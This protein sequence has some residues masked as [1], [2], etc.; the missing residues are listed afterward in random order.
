MSR[1]RLKGRA[2][3]GYEAVARGEVAVDESVGS[4]VGE[5]GRD[6]RADGDEGRV[7]ETRRALHQLRVA[8]PAQTQPV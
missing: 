1:A 2:R 3:E 4:E 5:A 8:A 7:R 6:V